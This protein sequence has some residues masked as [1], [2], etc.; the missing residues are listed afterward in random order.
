[1]HKSWDP[2]VEGTCLPF[3]STHHA[4]AGW[5]ILCG[6]VV[7]FLPIPLLVKL[8]V[9]TAQKAGLVCLFLLG[10]FTTVCSV[11]RLTQIHEIAYGDGDSTLL[12]LL[13]T[14]E[15]NVGVSG[16]S[17]LWVSQATG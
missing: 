10:L 8:K 16:H 17:S 12:I 14:V 11:F 13:G 7:I 4:L 5:S 15:L 2:D 1:V 9:K 3:G 6:L